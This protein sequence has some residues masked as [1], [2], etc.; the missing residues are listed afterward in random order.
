MNTPGINRTTFD[1][2]MHEK[3]FKEGDLLSADVGNIPLLVTKVYEQTKW[4]KFLLWLGFSVPLIDGVKVE[5]LDDLEIQYRHFNF[6][7]K[8]NLL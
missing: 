4:R 2:V 5:S 6:L 8:Y 7:R 1:L 3:Y